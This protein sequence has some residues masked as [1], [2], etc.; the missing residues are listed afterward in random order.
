MLRRITREEAIARRAEFGAAPP[1]EAAEDE[2]WFRCIY[3]SEDTRL[4]TIYEHRPH[5]CSGYP[6]YPGCG[7][8]RHT[9]CDHGCDCQGGGPPDPHRRIAGILPARPQP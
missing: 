9:G 8:L 7:S 3:W 6:D 2:E 1:A 4:C 5:M